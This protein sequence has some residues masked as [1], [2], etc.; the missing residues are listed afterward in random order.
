M[1]SETCFSKFRKIIPE[2]I[3][4]NG[5]RTRD[6][7][8][9]IEKVLPEC[10]NSEP[11]I[12]KSGKSGLRWQH[13]V[14]EALDYLHR[15]KVIAHEGDKWFINGFTDSEFE[16]S[17]AECLLE[18]QNSGLEKS[19]LI[20]SLN[21]ISP[22]SSE[23]ITISGK[24]L[25]RDYDTIDKL[26]RVRDY[27]CQICGKTIPKKMGGFYIEAAHIQAKKEKGPETPDNLLILCPNHHKEFDY[28]DLEIIQ[29]TKELIIFQLNGSNYCIPLSL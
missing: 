27:R 6:I 26:K 18:V 21:D 8:L 16:Y 28:G 9:E 25:K 1:P 13:N 12:W 11:Y 19:R 29:H 15:H 24:R 17:K 22:E 20:E 3:K 4:V 2:T 14:R 7:Y 23:Y 10:V 5:T